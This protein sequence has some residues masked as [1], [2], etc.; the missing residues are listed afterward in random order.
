MAYISGL[1]SSFPNFK[2]SQSQIE[3]FG[4]FIFRNNHINNL[5]KVYKNSGVK[6][7]Y[8]VENLDWYTSKH[9]WK[10]RNNLFKKHS[11]ELLKKC[12]SS[13]LKK[14][15]KSPNEISGIVLINSTGI[16]TP[17]LDAELINYFNFPGHTKRLPIF[18]YGCAG[19]VL[20]L[21]RAVDMYKSSFKTVL[22]CCVEICSLTFRP[23]IFSKANIVSTALFGDGAVSFLIGD[24][25]DCEI[26]KS[27]EYTWKNTL[28]LM[29]WNVENDSLGVLFDKSIPEFISSKLKPIIN[30]F[31][32]KKIDGFIMHPGGSKII[33][34]YKKIFSNHNS[35]L[36]SK[37]VLEKYGNVSSVTIFL[38]LLTFFNDP[39]SR[40]N[41]LMSA[42]GP[43]FTAGLAEVKI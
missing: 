27:S 34:S 42:L 28:N 20:G 4:K 29:G 37:E 30:D 22:V 23:Q 36:K 1:C 17:T 41:F 18:G 3:E 11:I 8:L 5:L 9:S 7:R 19:G 6:T 26:L 32:S 25:G 24:K 31:T 2:V 13:T 43:G 16:A 15:N 35:L 12:I 33:N 40:G 21:S 14:T 38:V 39:M 10:E